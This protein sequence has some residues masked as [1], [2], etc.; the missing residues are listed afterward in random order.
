M[1]KNDWILIISVI[2]YSWMFYQQ[3]PGI[4]FL[5]FSAAL[6]L[7]LIWR[8]NSV[9]KDSNWYVAA[10]GT[11]VSGVCVVLFGTAV[12]VVANIVS[13]SL[14][15]AY[16]ISR[17]SSVILAGLYSLYSYASSVGFMI[18]DLVKR[19]TG[20]SKTR[21]SRFW[22]RLGIG[23]GILIIV[24]VFFVLYQRSNPL[25]LDLTRKIKLDFISWPWVRF[26]FLG[27]LLLYGFFY[28]RNFPAWLRW[29]AGRSGV[30][31]PEIYAAKENR[32]FG[33]PVQLSWEISSG[34]I[35]LGLLNLL[36]LVVNVLDIYYLWITKELPTGMTY[37]DYVHQGTTNL[38][39][40]IV[41]AILII[42]FF[43]RGHINFAEKG[44]AI[45]IVA[46]LWIIQNIMVLVS[47]GYRN[48]LYISEYS[49]TYRRIGVYIWLVLTL[50]GLVTTFMKIYGKKS[51]WYLFR[52]NGW[53]FYIILVLFACQNW[54][55]VITKFNIE[56]SKKL[57]K[58]YLLSLESPAVIPELLALP[59]NPP[60]VPDVPPDYNYSY[61]NSRDRYSE[62]GNDWD[63]SKPDFTESLHKRMYTFLVDYEASDWQSWNRGDEEIA[64]KLYSLSEEGIFNNLV[65]RNMGLDSLGMIRMFSHIQELDVSLNH[66]S[67]LQDFSS[68]SRLQSL[69]LG[70][71]YLYQINK[72][73]DIPTL[74]KLWLNN[75][76]INDFSPLGKF[77]GL[78]YL[79]LSNNSGTIDL[80]SLSG[81]KK[82]A[83]L[84]LG[85]NNVEDYSAL[86]ELA[87][88]RSLSLASQQVKDFSTLPVLAKLEEID[89]SNNYFGS[90]NAVLLDKFK[91]FKNLKKINLSN[92]QIRSL[93]VLTTYYGEYHGFLS[94]FNN[95]KPVEALFP[96]LE[97]LNISGNS[98]SDL[99]AVEYYKGLKNLDVSRNSSLD[100]SPLAKLTALET[101]NVASTST[102]TLDSL[103]NLV[104]L[105][106]LDI[107][108]NQVIDIRAIGNMKNLEKLSADQCQIQD[109]TPLSGLTKLRVLELKSSYVRDLS[110]AK[111]LNSLEVLNLT[112]CS[113]VDFSP[114]YQLDNLKVL[115][116]DYYIDKKIQK[117]LQDRM[118]G[119]RI[120]YG[121][122]SSYYND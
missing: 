1:K 20:P 65:L 67:N 13:I 107:S 120:V 53:A 15:S 60:G 33:K 51:N 76:S 83:E 113:I 110:F 89:L 84:D 43:F 17:K 59:Q 3:S 27:F 81:M 38:I 103:Q 41:L 112:G 63:Y 102:G 23:A 9:L 19:K 24:I 2:L 104:H 87:S 21:G 5:I 72:L 61:D 39:I 47:T 55:L 49:L 101:L 105:K 7:L 10:S 71:N 36:L 80:K 25:F 11:L 62:Y 48:Y 30:M 97:E 122:T 69:N 45:K 85:T 79:S 77:N 94:F 68:F 106:D 98:I 111:N 116:L 88:L 70:F 12:S 108:N 86:K 40:S 44:K 16:S 18:A 75:N 92:N 32:I 115:Y 28:H 64:K 22:I 50:I 26:T 119:T 93:L 118:P 66:I 37:S 114:L 6:I 78:E 42:L 57:D 31:N 14:L 100:I 99:Q 95:P 96:K 109:F 82:L 90:G 74:K 29:D 52:S 73:P 121:N 34:V 46:F 35:L 8:N 91:E 4:N 56:K 58:Y 117:E 54:D